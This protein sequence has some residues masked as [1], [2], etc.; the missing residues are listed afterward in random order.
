MTVAGFE[1][2]LF[3]DNAR[4]AFLDACSFVG[5]YLLGL[6][7]YCYTSGVNEGLKMIETHPY[8]LQ[9]Y[10]QPSLLSSSL[11]N[12]LKK[13]FTSSFGN[14][15][16]KKRKGNNSLTSEEQFQKI[17]QQ[18]KIRLAIGDKPDSLNVDLQ[19]PASAVKSDSTN[20]KR[21]SGKEMVMMDTLIENSLY[22]YLWEE[23]DRK[24]A[25]GRILIW[26]MIPV[27]AETAKYGKTILTIA[28]LLL[29]LT[30]L[31]QDKPCYLI[32]QGKSSF[33]LSSRVCYYNAFF[34][35]KKFLDSVLTILKS[36]KIPVD[37]FLQS[38]YASTATSYSFTSSNEVITK[39]SIEFSKIAELLP[40]NEKDQKALLEWAYYEASAMLRQYGELFEDVHDY[41]KTGTSTVGQCTLLIEEKL[42]GEKLL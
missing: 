25:L 13:T 24:F 20:V 29:C 10:R 12:D 16:D 7:S 35:G 5:G 2:L 31:F 42:Q 30:S 3:R 34:R 8:S 17:V 38:T 32:L 15:D 23:E 22:D 19:S 11:L 37:S 1:R 39:S 41:L 33:I 40:Q 4:Q 26:L 21:L 9:I 14:I 27:A 18:F 28:S 36:K 6:P